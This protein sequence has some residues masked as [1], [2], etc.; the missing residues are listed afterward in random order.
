[1]YFT[2]SGVQS[3]LSTAAS[4]PASTGNTAA[5]QARQ[6][7]I[8]TTSSTSSS[9]MGNTAADQARQRAT[10]NVIKLQ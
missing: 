9:S 10:L 6:R 2:K 8:S 1:M 7:A 3:S 5:D 4:K